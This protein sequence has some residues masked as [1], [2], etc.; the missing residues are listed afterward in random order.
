MNLIKQFTNKNTGGK[1]FPSVFFV[2]IS[3]FLLFAC[4]GGGNSDSSNEDFS[5]IPSLLENYCDNI[6]TPSFE[7]FHNNIASFE[8]L[9]TAYS[10][11]EASLNDCRNA[12]KDARLSWQNI[13]PFLQFGPALDHFLM[14][15]CNTYPTDAEQ[16]EQDILNGTWIDPATDY[17]HYGLPAIEYILYSNETHSEAQ[18]NRLIMLT[19]HLVNLSSSVYNDWSNSYGL[20]FKSN[21]GTSAG[22]SVSLLVHSYIQV[23]ETRVRNGK[24]GY[25]INVIGMGTNADLY[26]YP[27]KV[28]AYFSGYSV[29]LL[30]EAFTTYEDVYNG[31]YYVN[32]IKTEGLG[33]DDFVRS[34]GDEPYGIPLDNE[35]SDQFSVAK[36][37]LQTLD[38]PLSSFVETNITDVFSAYL[39]LQA[40][41][42]LWKVD[43]TSSI[44]MVFDNS[45]DNDGD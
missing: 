45:Y 42:V 5:E 15:N 44:G 21:T 30:D 32:G 18:I 19:N 2:F 8:T 12:F 34:N 7:E 33:L 28:E 16:I 13:L 14:V 17:N 39:E 20:T 41:V 43:M 22:S 24:L 26:A 1:Y 31:D 23:Y 10:N 29:D 36:N 35:I 9:L 4:S 27:N 11:S 3:S 40:L 38:N 6:I 37:A 25:P